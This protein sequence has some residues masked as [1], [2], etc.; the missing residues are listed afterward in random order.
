[1]TE[2]MSHK[3]LHSFDSL[4]ELALWKLPCWGSHTERG[5]RGVKKRKEACPQ[6]QSEPQSLTTQCIL[7][8]IL[9]NDLSATSAEQISLR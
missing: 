4:L 9:A 6:P 1:M 3:R 8:I 7:A 2:R 5:L